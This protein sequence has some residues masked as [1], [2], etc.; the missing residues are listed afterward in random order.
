[1]P[2]LPEFKDQGPRSPA[3][4]VGIQAIVPAYTITCNGT[5]TR[6]GVSTEKRGQHDI[7]LQVWRPS[8][9]YRAYSLVGVNTFNVKPTK[10]QKAFLLTPRRRHR[11][12]VQVGDI[13]GFHLENNKTIRDDFSIQ[14]YVN[15]SGINVHYTQI[16]QPLQEI[17]FNTLHVTLMNA[18]PI[19]QIEIGKYSSGLTNSR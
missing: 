7:H 8:E 14:Y 18:S 15:T 11:I 16:A 1:M 6:W 13:L 9:G 10:G 2:L 3:L 4:L 19:I 17:H 12:M 5:L